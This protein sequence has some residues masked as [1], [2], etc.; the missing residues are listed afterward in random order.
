MSDVIKAN[1]KTTLG[2][3]G[4]LAAGLGMVFSAISS[5]DYSHMQVAIGLISTGIAGI[6][7]KDA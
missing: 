2:G 6:A 4:S 7:A 3:I 5:N 1:W